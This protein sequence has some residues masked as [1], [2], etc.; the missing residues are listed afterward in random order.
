MLE[1]TLG[2]IIFQDQVLEVAIAFAGFSTGEAEGLRRAMSR[3]RS[4]AAI[5]AYHERFIEG[6]RCKH[7]VDEVIAKRVFAMVQGFSGFGFPK[8]HGAA[9]GLL[10]YQSTWL[11]VHYGPEFLCSLLNEQPMGF[12]PPDALIH[13]AQRRGIEV[14]PPNVNSSE[15]ECTLDEEGCVR[16]GLGYVKGVREQEVKQ[17]VA[18]RHAAGRFLKLSDLASRAGAG[19]PSLELLA[20]SGACDSLVGAGTPRDVA[21]SGPSRGE[22][23]P[24]SS[25][26]RNQKDNIQVRHPSARRIALWQLGVAA[27]GKGVP[28]G[29]Q[30][31][32]PLDL[33]VPP[34]LRELSGWE[35][36]LADYGTTGLTVQSHPLALLRSRL[37]ANVVTSR[38]LD[39]LPHGTRVKTGGMVVARQRPGTANGIVFVLLEDEHGTI[40][41]IVPSSIYERHRLTV[42]T[43]PLMLV[44]GKLERFAAAGG[45]TNVLVEHVGSIDAPDRP[46]AEI[47]DFSMLDEQVRRGLQE[48]RGSGPPR[49]PAESDTRLSRGRAARVELRRGAAAMRTVAL[50]PPRRPIAAAAPGQ[51]PRRPI[52]AAAC[53]PAR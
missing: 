7:G 9:F 39:T 50:R 15:A 17:L 5:R 14:L 26:P 35:S 37:P 40:N 45:A 10:A 6:A 11:R 51:P 30:L 12:Y 8:A 47:K 33:P 44:E 52:A 21:A 20:W 2:G 42:R 32:L 25:T 48:Q 16:V 27:P 28:G 18:A 13:E 41:L 31:A 43:E 19:A 53:Q 46:M 3:K 49:E 38:D 36:M 34:R 23:C 4:E 22:L 24:S 29:V 1:E